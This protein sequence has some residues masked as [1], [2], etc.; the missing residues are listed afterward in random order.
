MQSPSS[1]GHR[2]YIVQ[3]LL[4]LL[5]SSSDT[6]ANN[7][8]NKVYGDA[9]KEL[10]Q[11]ELSIC[12]KVAEKYPKNYY[13]WTQRRWLIR[14]VIQTSEAAGVQMKNEN[15]K[16]GGSPASPHA[17]CEFSRQLIHD[18]FTFIVQ[19]WLST[20]VSDHSAVHYGQQLLE[21][22]LNHQC[23]ARNDEPKYDED[24]MLIEL[25]L[26][27]CQR[28]TTDKQFVNHEALWIF[29]RLIITTIL[30]WYFKKLQNNHGKSDGD[31]SKSSS[32]DDSVWKQIWSTHICKVYSEAVVAKLTINDAVTG[33]SDFSSVGNSADNGMTSFPQPS[34]VVHAWTYLSWILYN[35]QQLQQGTWEGQSA[36]T[37]IAVDDESKLLLVDF[38]QILEMYTTTKN[39]LQHYSNLCSLLPL[40]S[41]EVG[42]ND[43]AIIAHRFWLTKS[44]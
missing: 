1:W 42:K 22:W 27:S 7:A 12:T 24:D 44:Q 26:S 43:N 25:A 10:I 20:H 36:D 41:A 31:N 3:R 5:D 39:V 28:Y 38:N 16:E 18:E 9:W 6:S 33:A 4:I 34:S 30:R 23:I 11:K 14:Q 37:R 15:N 29:R 2:K 13:A 40:S 8:N 35:L 19:T 32:K 21:I 17:L